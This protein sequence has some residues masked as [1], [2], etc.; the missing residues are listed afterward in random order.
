[1]LIDDNLL[2]KVSSQAQNSPRLRMNYNLHESLDDKVQRMFN[3]MEPG[4]FIPVHRHRNTA[5]TMIVVRGEVK[6]TIFDDDRN[7]TEEYVMNPSKGNYGYHVPKCIWHSVEVTARDTVMFEVKE[8]PYS[9][10]TTEDIM[11]SK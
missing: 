2:N 10:L 1:M 3:A 11:K 8:G 6:I 7:I 4:T 5:E 9:P